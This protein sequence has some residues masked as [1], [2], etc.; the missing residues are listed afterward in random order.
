VALGETVDKVGPM[1]DIKPQPDSLE[2]ISAGLLNG[3]MVTLLGCAFASVVAWQI[4]AQLTGWLPD[5]KAMTIALA[6][7]GRGATIQ[8]SVLGAG[9]ILAAVDLIW[10]GVRYVRKNLALLRARRG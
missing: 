9:M 10:R 3:A 1:T 7:T 2:D 6:T 4:I 8:D 5:L